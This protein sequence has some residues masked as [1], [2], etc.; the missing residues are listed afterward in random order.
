MTIWIRWTIEDDAAFRP[1][2]LAETGEAIAEGT[3]INDAETHYMAGSSRCTLANAANLGA[4][5]SDVEFLTEYPE[6][7]TPKQFEEM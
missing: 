2:Y 1:A 3:P 4:D 5:F 7:W 6:D